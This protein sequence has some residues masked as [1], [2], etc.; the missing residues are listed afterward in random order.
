MCD[1]R[2]YK[3]RSCDNSAAHMHLTC[4]NAPVAEWNLFM[5]IFYFERIIWELSQTLAHYTSF[6]TIPLLHKQWRN[7][8]LCLA[9]FD[10]KIPSTNNNTSWVSL[11][12]KNEF[13]KYIQSVRIKSFL[14]SH[15]RSSIWL[16]VF[17]CN[18]DYSI[19]KETTL[20]LIST[21]YLHMKVIPTSFAST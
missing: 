9:C 21:M 2:R 13:I 20:I 18:D 6:D 4:G 10:R 11:R 3:T 16:T 7:L 8:M 17:F 14:F 15:S 1:V 12:F 5:R 19:E